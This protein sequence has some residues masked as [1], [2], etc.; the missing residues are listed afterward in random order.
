MKEN[1]CWIDE[2]TGKIMFE[3][4]NMAIAFNIEKAGRNQG[5]Y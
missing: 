1:R 5:V 4:V 3:D 2:A